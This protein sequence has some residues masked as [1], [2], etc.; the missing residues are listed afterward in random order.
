MT[1]PAIVDFPNARLSFCRT[2][3]ALPQGKTFLIYG[4]NERSARLYKSAL[5]H[6]GPDRVDGFVMIEGQYSTDVDGPAVPLVDVNPDSHSIIIAEGPLWLSHVTPLIAAGHHD[7]IVFNRRGRNGDITR[8]SLICHETQTIFL[9]NLKVLYSSFR[10]Y[11]R[12]TFAEFAQCPRTHDGLSSYVDITKP[13]YADFKTFT[14]VRNPFDRA[15]SCYREKLLHAPDHFNERLWNAPLRYLF[16]VDDVSF[17]TF[18][19]FVCRV[20]E[21]FSDPHVRLQHTN[22]FTPDGIAVPE[23]VGRF[24]SLGDE[25]VRLNA[26][27]GFTVDLPHRNKSNKQDEGYKRYFDQTLQRKLTDRCRRDLEAFGYAFA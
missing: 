11:F 13:A 16:D 15:V 4:V 27:L 2:L 14:F 26:F 22:V 1:T 8:M 5:E 12:D 25:L 18:V 21:P 17:E 3:E 24:E 23:F 6:L 10:D 20:P 9:P 7:L 19:E